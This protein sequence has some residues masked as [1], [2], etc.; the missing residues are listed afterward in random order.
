MEQKIFKYSFIDELR[1]ELANNHET[2]KYFQKKFKFSGDD[3]LVNREV[4]QPADPKLKLPRGSENYDFENAV[5]I[6]EMYKNL[7]RIQ[8]SDIRFWTYLSHVTFWEYMKKRNPIESMPQDKRGEYIL[9][10]WFLNGLNPNTIFRQGIAMLWW[11][12]FLTY[13]GGKSD[14][15]VLTKELFSMRDYTRTI[16]TSMQGRNNHFT[17]TLLRHVV[18]NPKLFKSE[19][20]TKIR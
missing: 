2:E 10:H 17:K 15:Y 6:Y 12:A 13:E 1:K 7:D 16:I 20:E 11:G 8:A 9:E 5:I 3:T 18:E 4:S 19:K 14:P